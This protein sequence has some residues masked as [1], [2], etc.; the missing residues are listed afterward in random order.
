MP[1]KKKD[2]GAKAGAEGVEGED[3]LV[4]NSNYVKYCKAIGLPSCLS[5][6]RLLN[7]SEKYPIE[8]IIIDD[9][10][11]PIGP[12]GTRALMTAIMGSGP[13]MK[14]GPYKL[15]KFLRIWK[16]NVGDDGASSIAEVLRLGGADVKLAFLELIDD[17]IGPKGAAALGSSLSTGQNLSL[18]TLNLDYNTTLGTDGAR[19]LCRG[20]RTNNTL[21]Q[22][23]LSYCQLTSASGSALADLLINSNS[24]LNVLSLTGNRLGGEGLAAL[25]RGLMHNCKLEKLL[26][27][28][29]MIEQAPEDLAALELFRDCLLNPSVELQHVDLMWNRIGEAGGLI[30]ATALT[31]ENKKISEFLVDLS[32]P[33]PLFEQLSR[34]DTG[35]KGKK[36]K[37]KNK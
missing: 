37:S 30:L 12:G 14:G 33:M 1:P 28:D 22:L 26:I 36:G 35:K 25:S 11:G 18:L 2:G 13:G 3:P 17:N 16:S 8:Q 10:A 24:S 29:N 32:L 31:S 19:A 15:L 4:L 34:R 9:D 7:D 21:K 5:V 20:L 23:H 27:A 6:T